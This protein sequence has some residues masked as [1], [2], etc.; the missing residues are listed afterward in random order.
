MKL[1]KSYLSGYLSW[2]AESSGEQGTAGEGRVTVSYGSSCTS[3][4]SQSGVE[5]EHDELG[6]V[7]DVDVD[8]V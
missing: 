4:P 3:S 5:M 6:V 8:V 7:I 2:R 1:Y